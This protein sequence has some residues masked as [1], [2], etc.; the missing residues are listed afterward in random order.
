MFAAPNGSGW[1]P[2]DRAEPLPLGFRVL[3]FSLDGGTQWFIPEPLDST[4]NS[5]HL[6]SYHVEG[7][8][9]QLKTRLLDSR[10]EDNYGQLRVSIRPI[11]TLPG[12]VA[13][14]SGDGNANDMV[15]GNHGALLGGTAFAPGRVGEAF[16]FD[17]VDDFIEIDTQANLDVGVNSGFTIY[18][19]IL[20]NGYPPDLQRVQ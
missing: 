20:P 11:R 6:Y 12:Q 8:G 3:Q 15:G 17:G 18:A 5:D 7:N 2:G 14:W 16:S 4:F 1:C 13:R 9:H 19:W 10:T